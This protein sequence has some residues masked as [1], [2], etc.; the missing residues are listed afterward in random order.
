MNAVY[1]SILNPFID[2]IFKCSVEYGNDKGIPTFQSKEELWNYICILIIMGIMQL[3]SKK[4]HFSR[5]DGLYSSYAIALMKQDRFEDLS[6]SFSGSKDKLLTTEKCLNKLI[7]VWEVSQHISIDEIMCRF[8]GRCKYRQHIRGKPNS[9]GLKLFGGADK[10][11]YLVHFWLYRG[12]DG[13]PLVEDNLQNLN[14]GSKC[15]LNVVK[16]T[17]ELCNGDVIYCGDSYFG[18]LDLARAMNK[19]YPNVPYIFTMNKNRGG[20]AFKN[21]ELKKKGDIF[22]TYNEKEKFN[23]MAVYD[24][25]ICYFVSNYCSVIPRIPGRRPLMLEEYNRRMPGID[26]HDIH[27][28][29]YLYPHKSMKWTDAYLIILLKIALVDTWLLWK[30]IRGTDDSQLVFL[31]TIIKRFS[32]PNCNKRNFIVREERNHKNSP[33]KECSLL[34]MEGEKISNCMFCKNNGVYSNARYYCSKCHIP[35]HAKCFDVHNK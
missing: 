20:N 4:D 2:H 26:T 27:L 32:T 35:L 12:S 7:K 14:V 5:K 6:K 34:Q 17:R 30:R 10:F 9:T 22:Y 19:N 8:K 31:N 33:S 29:R 11:G 16:N 3:P 1:D 13:E 24:S 18:S 23:A 15:V 21:V 28:S 25:K